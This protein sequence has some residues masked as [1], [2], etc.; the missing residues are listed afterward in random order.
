MLTP[1]LFTL[2]LLVL[3]FVGFSIPTTVFYFLGAIGLYFY[4]SKG[5]DALF[6][7]YWNTVIF[8]PLALWLLYSSGLPV[9]SSPQIL[10]TVAIAG[11]GLILL[12]L[13]LVEF[14]VKNKAFFHN[15]FYLSVF[16]LVSGVILALKTPFVFGFGVF[17]AWVSAWLITAESLFF[18]GEKGFRIWAISAVFA[19][20]YA[21]LL[22]VVSALSLGLINSA[23][24]LAVS[25]FLMFETTI[26]HL[27]G[28]LNR[29]VVLNQITMF[30]TV[31]VLIFVTAN[32]GM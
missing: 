23:L 14:A 12:W 15:I 3:P 32:W 4:S 2:L 25:A 29:K 16:L 11:G 26:R 28:E 21:Q 30:V 13:A 9:V 31:A 18:T 27:K 6:F 5:R 8:L 17:V 10:A 20:V 7:A 22:W 19:F 1:S 24:L